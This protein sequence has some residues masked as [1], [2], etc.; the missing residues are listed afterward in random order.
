VSKWV[1]AYSNP[2]GPTICTRSFSFRWLRSCVNDIYSFPPQS[3]PYLLLLSCRSPRTPSPERRLPLLHIWPHTARLHGAPPR[4][5][6]LLPR[7]PINLLVSLV[8]ILSFPV[9]EA[10][11]D[12]GFDH[13]V[14]YLPDDD[15]SQEGRAVRR[16]VLSRCCQ[17]GYC[18]RR[19]DPAAVTVDR[20]KSTS[21][22][23]HPFPFPDGSKQFYIG[24]DEQSVETP[25]IHPCVFH[26]RVNSPNHFSYCGQNILLT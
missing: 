6:C 11:A 18:R 15:A 9:Q 20:G 13:H 17:P 5:H 14:L 24:A 26:I 22:S 4:L 19:L 2:N 10:V 16:G 21:P 12:D 23:C 1:K 7:V 3:K 25:S 8:L